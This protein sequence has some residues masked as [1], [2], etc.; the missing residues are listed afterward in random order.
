VS[1]LHSVSTSDRP[2]IEIFSSLVAP[3]V[4]RKETA[5]EERK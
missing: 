1:T 5:G 4:R 3:V 2:E